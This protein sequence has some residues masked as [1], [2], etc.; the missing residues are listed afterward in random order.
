[1]VPR[2]GGVGRLTSPTV[3]AAAAAAA[4]AAAAAA[5]ATA[6]MATPNSGSVCGGNDGVCG[7]DA[8][9]GLEVR[10]A[11]TG[12]AAAVATTKNASKR[13]VSYFG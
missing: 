11:A 4:V 6:T 10:A 9:V 8:T 12:G 7:P 3:A 2:R 5:A 1:M 13:S